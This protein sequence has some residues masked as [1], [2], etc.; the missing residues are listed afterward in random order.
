MTTLFRRGRKRVPPPVRRTITVRIDQLTELGNV[1]RTF[2]RHFDS[3]HYSTS[4]VQW[5]I[6]RS[7]DPES[8]RITFC[9]NH[10]A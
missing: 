7:F 8:T 10:A 9:T 4:E 2:Y 6:W 1:Y 5:L 3:R